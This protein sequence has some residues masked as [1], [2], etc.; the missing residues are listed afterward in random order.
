MPRGVLFDIDGTLIDSNG[1]HAAAWID[2]LKEFGF[3]DVEFETVRQMIG[4]GGDKILPDLTGISEDDPRGKKLLDRRKQIFLQTYLPRLRAFPG[5]RALVQRIKNDGMRTVV[6]TS[7][8][9][10][11]LEHLLKV[12]DVED[13][14]DA[15]TSSS[16][17][18]ESKP[19]PDIL[20]AAVEKSGFRAEQLVMIGDTPY[21]VE[22][23]R[24]AGVPIIGVK[25]GGWDERALQ[26]AIAIYRDPEDLLEHYDLSL[27]APPG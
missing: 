18:E 12:A 5:A 21:D 4:M 2:A 1:A 14:M 27:L 13:L 11:E 10:E 15:T 7:A 23:S 19:D 6:A 24:R 9:R 16:D 3:T 8:N 20:D 25:C 22:A 26:G 17:A